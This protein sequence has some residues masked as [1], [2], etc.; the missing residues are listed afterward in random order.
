[1][2]RREEEWEG[3]SVEKGGDEKRRRE[4]RQDKRE[5]KDWEAER[6]EM[7]VAHTGQKTETK[8]IQP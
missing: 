5:V 7:G 1:M 4:N 8:S 3:D 6:R 2:N